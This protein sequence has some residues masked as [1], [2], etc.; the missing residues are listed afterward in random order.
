MKELHRTIH[1][2]ILW[3]RPVRTLHFAEQIMDH[4]DQPKIYQRSDDYVLFGKTVVVKRAQVNKYV[5]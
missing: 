5:P 2:G 3:G 4:P 1:L